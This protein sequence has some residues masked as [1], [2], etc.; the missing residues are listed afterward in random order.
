MYHHPK[1][2]EMATPRKDVLFEQD[3]CQ[4]WGLHSSLVTLQCSTSNISCSVRANPWISSPQKE[5]KDAMVRVFSIH[6]HSYS[7]HSPAPSGHLEVGPSFHQEL[8]LSGSP[9]VRRA[10][11]PARTL[12]HRPA[13]VLASSS[14]A[15]VNQGTGMRHQICNNT[16]FALRF[17]IT[18]VQSTKAPRGCTS[19]SQGE[20]T[21]WW[22]QNH[23]D[24]S[25]RDYSLEAPKQK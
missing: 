4:R 17:T 23:Q 16:C 18:N 6:A 20:A 14:L 7:N 3:P 22:S 1:Y 9:K 15:K 5:Q 12:G 19:P 10:P 24:P 11:W 2:L 25:S 13:R 21:H 8:T